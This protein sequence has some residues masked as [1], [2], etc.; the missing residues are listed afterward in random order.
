[1]PVIK[2]TRVPIARILSL[3]KD[4][5]TLEKIHEQ[6]DHISLQTFE[7]AL[8]EAATIINTI[9]GADSA[10]SEV[11]RRQRGTPP[12]T[13]D[14]LTGYVAWLR[15]FNPDYVTAP[16]RDEKFEVLYR[17][18][19]PDRLAELLNTHLGLGLATPTIADVLTAIA[20]PTPDRVI[21]QQV[22]RHIINYMKDR[23]LAL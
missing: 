11:E 9:A 14:T 13:V 21:L 7:K 3:L 2:G 5:Y 4:G 23:G 16:D 12:A 20:P 18:L 1:M 6:F 19:P 8:E 17:L 10:Y 22:T 15:L